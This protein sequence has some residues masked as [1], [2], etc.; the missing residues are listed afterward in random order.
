LCQ[1]KT[2][3]EY[4]KTRREIPVDVTTNMKIATSNVVAGLQDESDDELLITTVGGIVIRC[5]VQDIRET[6]RA[7]RGV[8]IQRLNEGDKVTAVVRLVRPKEEAAA[9][10]EPSPPA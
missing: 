3:K 5:P 2:V 10:G 4:S 8:R 1:Q 7:A 6:G 9:V